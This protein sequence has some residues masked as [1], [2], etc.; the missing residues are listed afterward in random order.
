MGW[1]EMNDQLFIVINRYYCYCYCQCYCCLLFLSLSLVW[2][3]AHNNIVHVVAFKSQRAI[4]GPGD[5]GPRRNE[6]RKYKMNNQFLIP[7]RV[8]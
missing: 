5:L 3:P 7:I 1:T 6:T 2:H 8:S 4:P